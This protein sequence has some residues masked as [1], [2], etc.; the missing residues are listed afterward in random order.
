MGIANAKVFVSIFV[1]SNNI[2]S[3]HFTSYT[4]VYCATFWWAIQA[5]VILFDHFYNFLTSDDL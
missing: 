5:K 4:T 2:F 3:V 1:T